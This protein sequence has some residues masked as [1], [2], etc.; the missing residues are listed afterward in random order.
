MKPEFKSWRSYLDFA[1]VTRY[2][3]RYIRDSDVD[4]FLETVLA[5][6]K[7]RERPI[8]K[9]TIFWRAQLGYDLEPVDVDGESIADL[10][11][12]FRFNRMKPVYGEAM[13][14]RANP[15]GIP[16][17]Y[18]ATQ[19]DT[20]LSEVRPWPGSLVSLAQLKT[21]RDMVI[22]DCTV[23]NRG[24]SFY[25]EEPG[26]EK[27]ELAVWRDI[28]RAFSEPVTPND[29]VADYA[30]TQI[31][32]ELFKSNGIDGIAYR[33]RFGTKGF[34]LVFFDLAAAEVINCSLYE[35]KDL[36]FH[37]EQAGNTYFSKE[38]YKIGS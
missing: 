32:A 6:S 3:Q 29:R 28:D 14:G 9:E 7:G 16:Y 18:V 38:H 33:S 22:I 36:S 5:T 11:R 1:G 8:P 13:E 34:N 23:K 10:P 24:D 35:A 17:L 12:A 21:L 26:P 37:F 31:L 19:K 30:P 27:K 15:K 20:A 4:T 2:R 25:F